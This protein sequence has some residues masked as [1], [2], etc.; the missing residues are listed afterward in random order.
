MSGRTDKAVKVITAEIGMMSFE[1]RA[2]VIARLRAIEGFAHCQSPEPACR[3]V[4][5]ISREAG[6]RLMEDWASATRSFNIRTCAG[7]A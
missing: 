7:E 2:E 4:E 1:Y 5:I 3:Y 6:K